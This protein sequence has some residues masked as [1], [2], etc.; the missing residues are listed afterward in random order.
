MTS[1]HAWW[2]HLVDP[3]WGSCPFGLWKVCGT[4]RQ[5]T[6]WTVPSSA[7]LRSPWKPNL[8]GQ[9]EL[10]LTSDDS[11]EVMLSSPIK[12]GPTLKFP[13]IPSWCV[14][15]SSWSLWVIRFY[16]KFAQFEQRQRET[17]RAQVGCWVQTKF[18]LHRGNLWLVIRFFFPN[19]RVSNFNLLWGKKLQTIFKLALDILPKGLGQLPCHAEIWFSQAEEGLVFLFPKLVFSPAQKHH[20]HHRT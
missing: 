6:W 15:D 14:W 16:I 8:F 17:E 20:Q 12:K 18:D 3:I 13:Q 4:A 11:R 2:L 9:K 19:P 5:R 10:G 7:F 1:P